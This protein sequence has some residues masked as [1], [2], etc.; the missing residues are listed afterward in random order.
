MANSNP[1]LGITPDMIAMSARNIPTKKPVAPINT[2]PQLMKNGGPENYNTKLSSSEEKEFKYWYSKVSKYKGLSKDPDDPSQEYDYRGYW[3]NEDRNGI[4]GDDP[5]AHFID[6]YKK[7]GHPTFSNESQYSNEETPGGNWSQ[8]K[9]GNWYF[10]HSPY[11]AKNI[12]KTQQYLRGT[13]EYSIDPN[14]G[15]VLTD[16][17]R[18]IIPQAGPLA[19]QPTSFKMSDSEMKAKIAYQ[20]AMG[21][22]SA[23]RMTQVSPPTYTFKG[24]E[25]DAYFNQPV[26]VPH[27]ET[28]THFMAS[29]GNYAVPFIQQAPQGLYFNENANPSNSE[30][31]RFETPEQALYFSENYKKVA[32]MSR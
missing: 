31:I 24:D 32:P 7:P 30:A 21:N 18:D 14:T 27:G 13:G 29:M 9:S 11:T 10:N 25:R 3:K 5:Y 12:A 20:A 6:K 23:Q 22:K 17:H 4:L 2:T 1:K 16:I 26:G 15:E 19:E 28:G 8:D